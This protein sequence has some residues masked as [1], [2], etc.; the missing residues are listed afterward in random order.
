MGAKGFREVLPEP[1][2]RFPGRAGLPGPKKQKI[3][4]NDL[5]DDSG[6]LID[7]FPELIDEPLFMPGREEQRP[8]EDS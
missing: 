4:G 8:A 2:L 1:L 7:A 6:G 5:I 3:A